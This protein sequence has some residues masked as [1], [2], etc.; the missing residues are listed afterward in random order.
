MAT[1]TKWVD[2]FVIT[3]K[4]WSSQVDYECT[5][6]AD[7]GSNQCSEWADEG[8]SH[9]TS[10]EK[11]HW[12]TPWNC[13]A[14]FFCRAYYWVAKWVCKAW[15]WVA[16]W[17]C[18]AFAW[19]VKAFCVVFSWAL[20][21]VCVAWDTLRCALLGLIRAIGSLFG[22][23]KGRPPRIEHVFVLMLENRSFDHML[24][25]SGIAGVDPDGNP[26]VFNPGFDPLATSNINPI[27]GLPVLVSSPADFQLKGVDKDPGHEFKE[28]VVAL[29]GEGAVY[30]PV[31]GGYPPVNNSGFIANYRDNGSPTPERIMRCFSPEQLPV[32]NRLAREFAVCDQWFSSLPGPTWPNRFFLLA[33]TSG[34]L[35]GSP[36][37]W[38]VVTS[39]TVEGYRFENGNIFDLLDANC[40][41]WRI[42]EG[43]DFPVSFAMKGMNLNRLQGRFK[44]FEDFASEVQSEAFG[45]KFVFIEPKYGAHKFDVTGPGDFACGNSM[46]PLDDVTRGERLIKDVYEAIRNSPHWE[47]S[48]LL[49]TFDEHGGFFDHAPPGPAVPPGD[50][51]TAAYSQ[52]G[53]QFDQLGVRVPA[54]VISPYTRRGVIDHTTYDH[55]S[56]L[57]TV[58]T[59]CGIGHLTDRDQAAADFLKLLP[60]TAPRSDAP[61]SLPDPAPNPDPLPCEADDDSRDDLMIRRSELRMARRRGLYLDRAVTEYPPTSTQIGFLQV[62]L[63]NVI[64]TAEYPERQ[65]WIDDYLAVETGVDAALFMTEATLKLKHGIDVKRLARDEWRAARQAG[66]ETAR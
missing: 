5:S 32:L 54:L 44:D 16:K 8:S 2:T 15:Y 50:L 57:K 4:N 36:D 29:C 60:L 63:L 28:T 40:I 66:K 7:E 19:V 23:G 53:F 37:K 13:I 20:Q 49:V 17:V 18:K 64:L 56:M 52:F 65:Q 51:E 27:T 62:A 39:T 48:L 58:E 26:T 55:T 43:D 41:P 22:R 11:C 1:C 6:W 31:P 12:Y 33:G 3:C 30:N 9:C 35:D 59:L 45:Y 42:Y 34:G 24:G 25:F 21:L 38:D 14:G 10:W 61:L 46:H 47:H